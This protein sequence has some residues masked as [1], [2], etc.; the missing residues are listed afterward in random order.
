MLSPR[1]NY[2]YNAITAA[3]A[4]IEA[5]E[6]TDWIFGGKWVK[7][8]MEPEDLVNERAPFLA[9]WLGTPEMA[10]WAA[11]SMRCD[12]LINFVGV[13]VTGDREDL[14]LPT[15]AYVNMVGALEADMTTEAQAG[16][17]TLQNVGRFVGVNIGSP[18]YLYGKDTLT[19]EGVYMIQF[20]VAGT[21]DK[22]TC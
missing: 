1:T 4:V 12:I 13:V 14:E 22:R 2:L 9:G 16:N 5:D 21:I 15:A 10:W 11:A 20:Q 17:S 18:L 8:Q 19:D 7:K 3:W 6:Y